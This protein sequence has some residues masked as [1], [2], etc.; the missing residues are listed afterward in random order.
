MFAFGDR[1]REASELEI[2]SRRNEL[3][4]WGICAIFA[5]VILLLP[6]QGLLTHQFKTFLAITVFC[7]ALAAFE[8]VP[9]MFIAIVMPSL[10][11]FF[12][13]AEASVVMS[14]WVGTTMLMLCG[15]FFLGQRWMTAAYCAG[16]PIRSCAKSRAVILNFWPV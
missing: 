9:E 7:L 3:I 5:I 4:K 10:W 12:G 14:S 8:L 2:A 1:I 13:A 15:A 6:E 11:I 16:S